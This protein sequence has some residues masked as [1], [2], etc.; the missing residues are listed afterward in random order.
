MFR[1]ITIDGFRGIDDFSMEGFRRVNVMVGRNGGGKTSILEAMAVAAAPVG[2]N[3]LLM[4]NAGRDMPPPGSRSWHSLL[5]LFSGMDPHRRMRFEY[6]TDDETASIEVD[7]I[8]GTAGTDS[9]EPGA[10]TGYE[11]AL[12]GL[13]MQ[14]RPDNGKE[15]ESVLE[16]VE[17][18][19]QQTV[20]GKPQRRFAGSFVIHARRAT[21]L[22]ETASALTTLYSN[23]CEGRFIDAIRKVDPRVQRLV[24]GTQ[25][26]Q[27]TVL[28]DL[29]GPTLVPISVLG[30]GFCRVALMV[31]GMVSSDAAKL[32]IVDEIDSGL[33]RSVMRGLWESV[34]ELSRQYD[35]QVFCS[36]HNE[37]M[38]RQTLPAFSEEPD[39]L[40]VYRIDRST[41]GKVSQQ[42]YDYEMLHDAE[43]AGMDVR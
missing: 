28:A 9:L 36:T 11:E 25:G 42:P 1:K 6:E 8:F 7:A 27:P 2:P 3:G 19:F 13:R 38:L 12:R 17:V 40:R 21:S 22:G 10:G 18:G 26:K 16:L 24:P 41:D 32:L 31:T 20:K 5:T 33:H 29:G 15:I 35:F 30:D 39:A 14:Y 4:A 37:E 43:A 23:K 34:L